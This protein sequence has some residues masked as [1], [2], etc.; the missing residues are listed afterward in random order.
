[1]KYTIDITFFKMYIIFIVH[2]SFYVVVKKKKKME[3]SMV[4]FQKV[5]KVVQFQMVSQFEKSIK[6][7]FI[8]FVFILLLH[9]LIRN[10]NITV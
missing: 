2:R 5:K 4:Q 8:K 9:T 7:Y 6:G 10:L 3:K 1:M